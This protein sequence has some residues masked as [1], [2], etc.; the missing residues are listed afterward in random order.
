M[1]VFSVCGIKDSGKTTTVEAIISELVRRGYKVG[2]VKDIHSENFAIDPVE[3]TN[4]NRHKRAGATLVTARGLFETDILYP[5]QLHMDDV[6]D[7]YSREGYEWVVL[8]GVDCI[9]IPTIVTAHGSDDLEQKWSDMAIGVSGR[10]A[11]EIS[12]HDKKPAIDATTDI[13][14]LVDLLELKVYERLPN[15]PDEC[16]GACGMNCA[17]LARAIV[18]GT[19]RRADCVAD[20]GIELLINGVRIQMVPFVQEILTNAVMGVVGTLRGYEK[21]AD[22]KIRLA[23]SF[24]IKDE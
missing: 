20:K 3:T 4:T 15:F 17:K 21:G 16:C 19:K 6:L 11:A 23:D 2:S 10:I 13:A 8:E 12:E 18:A 5:S 24:N 7:V 22:I 14:K 9:P 1:K